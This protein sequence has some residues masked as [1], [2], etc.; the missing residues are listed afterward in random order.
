MTSL[1]EDP[2]LSGAHPVLKTLGAT[3]GSLGV[4]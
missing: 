2:T 1:P 3:A 4:S